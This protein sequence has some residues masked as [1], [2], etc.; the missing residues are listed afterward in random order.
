LRERN[1]S[2]I[3]GPAI[4]FGELD[5]TQARNLGIQ[6]YLLFYEFL[7]YLAISNHDR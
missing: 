4:L 6:I 1:I 5:E 2:A 7:Q 3:S